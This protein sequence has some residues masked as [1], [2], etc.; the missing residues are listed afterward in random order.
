MHVSGIVKFNTTCKNM[1][2][3]MQNP[4]KNHAFQQD[5]ALSHTCRVTQDHLE[6]A[7][8]EFIKK[9]EWPSQ[10]PDCNSVNYFCEGESLAGRRR[11]ID[12]AGVK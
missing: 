8:P 6:V 3:Q 5:T 2:Y 7:T 12:Q 4:K 11:Q 10:S 1:Q 9:V